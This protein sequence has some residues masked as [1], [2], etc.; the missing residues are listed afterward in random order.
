MKKSI[1]LLLW[2]P[3]IPPVRHKLYALKPAITAI[4]YLKTSTGARYAPAIHAP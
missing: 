3:A 4:N 2:L 1:L